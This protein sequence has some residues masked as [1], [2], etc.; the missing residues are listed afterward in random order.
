M[1]IFHNAPV[2]LP[3]SMQL[4]IQEQYTKP[5][6]FY[7]TI[8]HVETLIALYHELEEKWNNPSAVYLAFLYHDIIYEYGAKDNEV[9][10][11]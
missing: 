2:T 6:R 7:H 4:E 3:L 1:N 9:V 10:T 8:E 5:K 11:S